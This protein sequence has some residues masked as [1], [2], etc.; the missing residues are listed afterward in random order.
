MRDLSLEEIEQVSGGTC[1][2]TCT[3]TVT[4]TYTFGGETSCTATVTCSVT[5]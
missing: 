1:H 2:T 4:C 3:A 5:C